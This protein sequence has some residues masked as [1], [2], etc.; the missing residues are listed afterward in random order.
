MKLY[1]MP[2]ACSLASH[3]VLEWIGASYETQ[4]LSHDQLKTE[5]YLRVNPLG[6]VPALEL[7]DGTVLTQ[8]TAVLTY[9]AD[10][11]P[12]AKLEGEGTPKG[13]AEVH[14]WVGL[15]NSDIHPAFKPLFGTTAY[16]GDAAMIEKSKANARERLRML[17]KLVDD[18]L[19]THDW[20]AG[21]R[22]IADAY[23]YVMSRWAHANALEI[24]DLD[25]FERFYQRMNDDPA[26]VRALQAEELT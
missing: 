1:Y 17:F 26:V 25:G 5:A 21:R 2:G 3:I 4:R 23:L 13:R 24:E 11:Y 6:A 14:R 18:Q 16:L 10:A 12:E 7:D 9:L 15:V 20:I 22:S 8:N 19:R